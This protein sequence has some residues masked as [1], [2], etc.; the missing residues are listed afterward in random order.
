MLVIALI[1]L[2]QLAVLVMILVVVTSPGGS[3]GVDLVEESRSQI[4]DLEHRTIE[5]MMVEAERSTY[6]C[7]DQ[8]YPWDE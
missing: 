1:A 6:D 3:R 4:S 5:A 8:S 7:S 2:V